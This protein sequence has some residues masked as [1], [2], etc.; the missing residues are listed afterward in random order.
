MIQSNQSVT[1][2]HKVVLLKCRFL[3]VLSKRY[4]F[5]FSSVQENKICQTKTNWLP[6]LIG[7]HKICSTYGFALQI[8][9]LFGSHLF[10]R[11][12]NNIWEIFVWT[13]WFNINRCRCYAYECNNSSIRSVCLVMDVKRTMTF[14]FQFSSSL[15]ANT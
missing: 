4:L 6:H 11:L 12:N 13:S 9:F 1:S 7:T 14:D 8:T 10:A 5:I 15:S 2:F 3:N